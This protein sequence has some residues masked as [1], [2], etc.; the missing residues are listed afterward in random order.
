MC[1][2][3]PACVEGIVAEDYAIVNP[4]GVRREVSLSL[5]EDDEPGDYVI[6]HLFWKK[7]S[8]WLISSALLN[9]WQKRYNMRVYHYYWR[10]QSSGT[11]ER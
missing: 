4:G 3:L 11:R 2:A 10:Y 8:L 5:V 7:A 9:R 6:V 1:F